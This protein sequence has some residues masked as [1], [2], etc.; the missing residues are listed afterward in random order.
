MVAPSPYA[1]LSLRRVLASA[2]GVV[3]VRFI[4][5]PRLAEYLGSPRLVAEGKSPLSSL[6]EMAAIRETG[7]GMAGEGPLGAISDQPKLHRSLLNSY[8]DLDR[9]TKEQLDSVRLIRLERK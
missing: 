5:L 2:A 6:V 4:V 7:S 1:G 3:N 9:L 8:R